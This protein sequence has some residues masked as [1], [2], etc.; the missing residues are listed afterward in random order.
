MKNSIKDIHR[1]FFKKI[2]NLQTGTPNPDK[3]I[4]WVIPDPKDNYEEEAREIINSFT[5]GG[6]VNWQSA[7]EDAIICVNKILSLNMFLYPQKNWSNK[8]VYWLGVLEEINKV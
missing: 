2:E 1:G 7:K 3:K 6:I 4:K 8:N 5:K